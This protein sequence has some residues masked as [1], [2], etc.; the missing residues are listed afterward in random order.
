MITSDGLFCHF[1]CAFTA[2][3][4]HLNLFRLKDTASCETL[5]D[6]EQI[7]AFSLLNAIVF[8][9]ASRFL[10]IIKVGCFVQETS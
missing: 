5:Q 8:K 4:A 3:L 6:Q 2:P 7:T 1:Y 10:L 9:V